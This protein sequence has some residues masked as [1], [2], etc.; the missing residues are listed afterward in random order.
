MFWINYSGVSSFSAGL[1]NSESSKGQVIKI[2][3]PQA[4]K[5]Y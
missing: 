3:V 4:A 5:V 1:H 2:N